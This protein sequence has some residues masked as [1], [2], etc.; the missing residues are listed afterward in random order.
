LTTEQKNSEFYE[1]SKVDRRH[2]IFL[3]SFSTP[4]E[5]LRQYRGVYVLCRRT[6]KSLTLLLP[7]SPSATMERIDSKSEGVIATADT[8]AHFFNTLPGS[9]GGGIKLIIY[10][11]H[12][13]HNRFYFNN[14]IIPYLTSAQGILQNE[15]AK[16]KDKKYNIAFPDEGAY[17]RFAKFF[18]DY[19]DPVVCGK[20]RVEEDPNKR[21]VKIIEGDVKG[22]HCVIVDD[23]VRSGGTLIE[24]QKGLISAG[25]TKVSA[26]CTHAIFPNQSWKKF[27]EKNED[28]FENFWVTNTNP[29]IAK[30]LV[31]KKPFVVL[32]ISQHFS[33]LL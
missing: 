7:F 17:K 15:L 3:C 18:S 30:E 21:I 22:R 6:I 27:T 12:T 9:F 29:L 23:L 24:C 28:V 5:Q 31:G 16:H 25:A 1:I 26:F 10:D 8:D 11:L 2:T 14:S 20:T 33:S 19:P 32:D 4:K 13:L